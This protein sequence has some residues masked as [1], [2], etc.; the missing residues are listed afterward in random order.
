[1]MSFKIEDLILQNWKNK[2]KQQENNKTQ[3]KFKHFF[4]FS[5]IF[6]DELKCYLTEIPLFSEKLSI[7]TFGNSDVK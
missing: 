7:L 2:T 6:I 4:F 1:M 5:G 3:N